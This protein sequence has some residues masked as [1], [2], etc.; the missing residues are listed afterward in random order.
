MASTGRAQLLARIAGVLA[1]LVLKLEK[2]SGSRIVNKRVQVDLSIFGHWLRELLKEPALDVSYGALAELLRWRVD[3]RPEIKN[4]RRGGQPRH[5]FDLGEG[6]TYEAL[7]AA[8]GDALEYRSGERGPMHGQDRLAGG[9]R[10][11]IV[12]SL[13]C[14]G[15]AGDAGPSTAAAGEHGHG[16]VRGS[17]ATVNAYPCAGP[18]PLHAASER[19]TKVDRLAPQECVRHLRLVV[20]DPALLRHRTVHDRVQLDLAALGDQ[21]QGFRCSHRALA[22][23][24]R[25]RDDQ[26]LKIKQIRWDKQRLYVY[27]VP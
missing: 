6:T 26:E 10:M 19:K 14:A 21:L 15:A 27:T 3:R 18:E 16:R 5:V 9:T 8:I 1:E 17:T 11:S 22:E 4:T 23:L 7:L 13:P 12:P 2:N 25:Q 20:A 24:F